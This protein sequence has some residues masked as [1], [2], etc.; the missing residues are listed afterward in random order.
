MPAELEHTG[1]CYWNETTGNL[2]DCTTTSAAVQGSL[3]ESVAVPTRIAL[4]E[5]YRIAAVPLDS[6]APIKRVSFR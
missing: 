2:H 5:S 4:I 3:H 6:S 1:N